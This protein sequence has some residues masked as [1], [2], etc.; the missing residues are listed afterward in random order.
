LIYGFFYVCYDLKR[1]RGEK[2]MKKNCPLLAYC[3]TSVSLHLQYLKV[4]RETRME[5]ENQQQQ[6]GGMLDGE[7]TY[8]CLKDSDLSFL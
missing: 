5:N 2:Q 6:Q 3:A 7:G 4:I 1:K 8:K